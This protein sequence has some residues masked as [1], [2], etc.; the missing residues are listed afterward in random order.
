MKTTPGQD[1]TAR[2]LSPA[3][4]QGRLAVT[5]WLLMDLNRTAFQLVIKANV[6]TP[7]SHTEHS[8]L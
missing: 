3:E 2:P 5:S 7:L 8:E 6:K 4:K 1:Y